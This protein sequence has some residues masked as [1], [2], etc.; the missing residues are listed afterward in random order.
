MLFAADSG[1]RPVPP[2]HCDPRARSVGEVVSGVLARR[3]T[4][5]HGG[6]V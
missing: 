4:V 6:A 2:G 3:V 1:Y 5:S